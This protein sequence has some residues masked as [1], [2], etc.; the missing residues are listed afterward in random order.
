M[1]AMSA[2]LRRHVRYPEDIFGIQAAVYTTYHMTL[3]NVF[4]SKEDQWQ[5]PSVDTG[6]QAKEMQPYYTVMRLPGEKQTE[7]IQMLPFTPRGRNNLSAWLA[8]RSDAEHYGRLIVFQFPKEKLING[9]LQIAG[10]ISQDP[11][12]SSRI[13]LWNQQGSSVVWGTLL[14]I[15]IEE[16]LLYVRPLYLQASSGKMPELKNVVIASQSRIVM[17]ETLKQAL[18]QIFGPSLAATLPDDRMQSSATS[19]VPSAADV[20]V[21]QPPTPAT[22]TKEPTQQDLI[23]EAQQHMQRATK[24]SRD[25]DWATFGVEL[26]K[27][28]ELLDRAAKIKK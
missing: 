22:A 26:K 6:Q 3:P 9:P 17:A 13:T 14:V 27:V 12:I 25:G 28:E 16:S 18:I 5:L 10:R 21:D 2:D 23:L 1:S 15:P 4:Y 11:Q 19:V 7:F 20:T 8:A 24:A